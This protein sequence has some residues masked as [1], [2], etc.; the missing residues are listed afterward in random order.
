M[1][2]RILGFDDQKLNNIQSWKFF[3]YI[4]EKN[5]KLPYL[6]GG[7]HKECPSY[8]RSPQPSKENISTSKL[9][10]S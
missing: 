8:R 4:F 7:L 6:S 10:I 2:I 9:E 1:L 5:C 3:L